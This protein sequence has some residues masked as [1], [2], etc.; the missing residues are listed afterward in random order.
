MNEKQLMR[1]FYKNAGLIVSM[2]NEEGKLVDYEV[3]DG[4]LIKL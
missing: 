1:H 4:E 3:K 2:K